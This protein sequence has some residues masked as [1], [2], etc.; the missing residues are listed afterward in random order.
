MRL[1]LTNFLGSLSAYGLAI[2]VYPGSGTALPRI[3]L[4]WAAPVLGTLAV[5]FV[6]KVSSLGRAFGAQA[7][8]FYSAIG[9]YCVVY[10]VRAILDTLQ[11]VTVSYFLPGA[12]FALLLG[13][14]AR[15]IIK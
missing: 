6:T 3:Y 1:F 4:I 13:I 14:L 12:M 8:A 2:F 5:W 15:R 11:Y 10:H 9:I 7:L